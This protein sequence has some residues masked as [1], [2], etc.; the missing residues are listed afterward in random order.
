MGDMNQ[1]QQQLNKDVGAFGNQ[2]L[3]QTDQSLQMNQQQMNQQPQQQ[4]P[5]KPK[6]MFCPI[7]RISIL[8]PSSE[9]E[10]KC[11][12]CSQVVCKN[13]G[14]NTQSQYNEVS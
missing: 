14:L 11:L 2:G 10:N 1:Q 7:C 9:L 8:M 13:C 3:T 12:D 6:D 5:Q 4:Q